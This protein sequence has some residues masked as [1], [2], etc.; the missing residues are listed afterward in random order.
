MENIEIVALKECKKSKYIKP[1]SLIY[2]QEG[3][4]KRWDLVES[5]DSVAILLY[6]TKKKSIILVRQFRPAL[7]IHSG[8]KFTYELCAGITDKDIPLKKIAQEEIIEETGYDV[9]LDDIQKINSFYT[10]V[11]FAGSKQTLFFAEV[12]ESMKKHNGG[13]ID[14]EAIE[15][16]YLSTEDIDSF[17]KDEDKPKT[18][19]LIYAFMWFLKHYTP[20]HKVNS[21]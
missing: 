9:P 14:D 16:I 8:Q 7:Y 1:K 21:S 10:A 4:K 5:H 12:D 20:D 15:V 13:G 2:K 3:I 19:G 6:H 17:I 18:S 11:G